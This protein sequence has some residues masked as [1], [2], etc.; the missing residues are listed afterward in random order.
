MVNVGKNS[1]RLVLMAIVSLFLVTTAFAKEEAILRVEPRYNTL[2]AVTARLDISSSGRATCS[3]EARTKQG[4]YVTYLTMEL[5]QVDTG[6][7]VKTWT[8][9]AT[10]GSNLR[11]KTWYVTSGH[12][13]QVKASV[14]VYSGS[15]L[16]ET[17]TAYS[18]IISY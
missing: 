7:T 15:S 8:T 9:S 16:V 11:D 6:D 2:S 17:A 3:S 10:G 5:I 13:Y 1:M 4:D 14:D 12:R 18:S